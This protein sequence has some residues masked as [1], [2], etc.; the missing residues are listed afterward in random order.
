MSGRS[1]EL[2]VQA[3]VGEVFG[4]WRWWPWSALGVVA[5][6]GLVGAAAA[7]ALRAAWPAS[8]PVLGTAACAGYGMVVGAFITLVPRAARLLALGPAVARRPAAVTA[9][10][11]PFLLLAAALRPTPITRLTRQEFDTAVGGVVGQARTILAHRFWPAW[12]TAF[13]VPVLG[14]MTAWRNGVQ[15][16][17]RMQDGATAAQVFP[18]FIAQVSPPMVAT[19]GASLALLVAVVALDQW[20]KGVLVRWRGVVDPA[21][22]ANPEMRDMLGLERVAGADE[23]AAP[24]AQP[25][26]S[27]PRRPLP[28]HHRDP[29]ELQRMWRESEPR[30]E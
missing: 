15:V 22:G 13:I 27:P 23:T 30:S 5:G 3:V 18:A 2:S 21:D 4:R 25:D 8:Q 1:R 16:Q 7:A 6:C 24:M 28:K 14:L 19:I 20:T 9:N 12:T 10:W 29:E 11:W 26:E 17:L